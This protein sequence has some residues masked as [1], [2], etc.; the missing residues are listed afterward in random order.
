VRPLVLT[1]CEASGD[2]LG[3]EVLGGLAGRGVRPPVVGISGPAMR[4]VGAN[5]ESRGDTD[6]LGAAGLVEIIPALP[7]L[8]RARNTLTQLLRDRAGPALLID[9]PDLHLPV[10]RRARRI[11]RC[12]IGMLVAPQ[13]WAWRPARAGILYE[14]VD[15]VLCLFRFEVEHLRSLGVLAHWV[16]HPAVDHASERP[17]N[18]RTREG[19]LRIALLPGSRRGEVQRTLGPALRGLAASLGD[20]PREILVPWRLPGPPPDLPNVTFTQDEGLDVLRSADLAVVAAGTATLEAALAGVPT[21]VMGRAH[22]ITAAIA[23]R[24]L[25]VR[26]IG[27]P[28]L[29]LNRAVVPEIVQDLSPARWLAPVRACL[30]DA[31]SGAPIASA[32]RD[33]LLVE[34]GPPGFAE[35]AADV[36]VPLLETP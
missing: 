22:P 29:I 28:N 12:P 20:R 18:V 24:A 33:E 5:L 17:F 31:E 15:F 19:G 13:Y 36:L 3:A 2:R 27:L 35:R 21:V 4:S 14:S 6:D 1:A 8:W 30:A 16:G 34:L 23:R 11:P 10:A 32:L 7:T 9:G 26:W 25:Q